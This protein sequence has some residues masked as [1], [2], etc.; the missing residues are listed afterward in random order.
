MDL[1]N[2]I[3]Y[4]TEYII[5]YLDLY[6]STHYLQLCNILLDPDKFV[7]M[8]DGDDMLLKDPNYMIEILN[9]LFY[10][11]PSFTDAKFK[12]LI[13]IFKS[14]P[15]KDSNI[16]NKIINDTL[17]YRTLYKK[18]KPDENLD[19]PGVYVAWFRI[20]LTSTKYCLNTSSE[21]IMS[22]TAI[23]HEIYQTYY[24]RGIIITLHA[25]HFVDKNNNTINS[26]YTTVMKQY[27]PI[28]VYVT[29]RKDSTINNPRYVITQEHETNMLKIKY[30]N[31][32]KPLPITTDNT[33]ANF[34]LDT[35]KLTS[36]IKNFDYNEIETY[37]L[38]HVKGFYPKDTF[39]EHNFNKDPE[40]QKNIITLI[41]NNNNVLIITSGQSGAGKTSSLIGFNGIDGVLI[42]TLNNLIDS[43][44]N[45]ISISAINIYANWVP[46]LK[47]FDD[48]NL[49]RYAYKVDKIFID[50]KDTFNFTPKNLIWISPEGSS[51]SEIINRFLSLR[52]VEPT[53][54]NPVSSRS[55]LI[56]SC[57][58]YKN[59]EITSH[60][61]ICDLAGVEDK[62]D[63]SYGQLKKLFDQYNNP[64]KIWFNN[65][66][67][68]SIN[69]PLQKEI[70]KIKKPK[71]DEHLCLK[72]FNNI[73]K[74]IN[75]LYMTNNPDN[76]KHDKTIYINKNYI[77]LNN[78]DQTI[79]VG[80][81]E[82]YGLETIN[83]T[84]IKSEINTLNTDQIYNVTPIVES[85]LAEDMVNIII[86]RI[87]NDEI[88]ADNTLNTTNTNILAIL[89]S[90]LA[91][92]ELIYDYDLNFYN[93]KSSDNY[94]KIIHRMECVLNQ[95]R[96]LYVHIR[97]YTTFDVSKTTRLDHFKTNSY[98]RHANLFL[99]LLGNHG[100]IDAL[101]T[102]KNKAK[103]NL[104][105]GYYMRK[106]NSGN[107]DLP[108]K[109][110]S[111]E[112]LYSPLIVDIKKKIKFNLFM[113]NSPIFS[114]CIEKIA[115][116]FSKY[117]SKIHSELQNKRDWIHLFHSN[118]YESLK[119]YFASNGSSNINELLWENIISELFTERKWFDLTRKTPD[120]YINLADCKSFTIDK[121]L[122][123]DEYNKLPNTTKRKPYKRID[124]NKS[125]F[126]RM[127]DNNQPVNNLP[128][129]SVDRIEMDSTIATI[130]SN[131][132]QRN[133]IEQLTNLIKNFFT[134]EEISNLNNKS[135]NYIYKKLQI[136]IKKR[137]DSIIRD[138]ITTYILE[139]N[140][141]LRIMEGYIINRSLT[142][143]RKA[144]PNFI[145]NRL[146][147]DVKKNYPEK[148][149]TDLTTTYNFIYN[150]SGFNYFA[151]YNVRCWENLYYF[152]DYTN[153]NPDI[154]INNN[155][156][157]NYSSNAV[158]SQHEAEIILRLIFGQDIQYN[159]NKVTTILP[160]LK[161]EAIKT[162][163]ILFCVVNTS[164]SVNNPPNPPFINTNKLKLIAN[165]MNYL[166]DLISKHIYG[167]TSD[168]THKEIVRLMF[169]YINTNIE[170]YKNSF[171]KRIEQ[172]EFYQ[173]KI[174]FM[175]LVNE[176]VSNPF[177]YEGA[178]STVT[179]N[180][181]IKEIDM[182]NQTTLIGTINIASFVQIN[183]NTD[184]KKTY[185]TALIC[186]SSGR[187]S[188]GMELIDVYKLYYSFYDLKSRIDTVIFNSPDNIYSGP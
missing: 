126:W 157:E 36:G 8:F 24:Q 23:W 120:S 21:T 106:F 79:N 135:Y 171:K 51:L 117:E 91:D 123:S 165:T 178:Y 38:G 149:I 114:L 140:M 49:V 76:W 5:K 25:K 110:N 166:Y 167:S 170:K 173:T 75:L 151:P 7:S 156:I 105:S 108:Y 104:G 141:Q 139:Y 50:G 133:D 74:V 119:Y 61:I 35:N 137:I 121:L 27:I 2:E 93:I 14:K 86:N 89:N 78:N 64:S 58:I 90:V 176:F 46:G 125:D 44:Y 147:G 158:N 34:T 3:Y 20:L 187:M 37:Y 62:F 40:G 66:F 175:H 128:N 109:V 45:K 88:E 72:R 159:V 118:S 103:T 29:E 71:L 111:I 134:I 132:D 183:T 77:T 30:N 57:S 6:Y 143:M 94:E 96:L 43:G 169:N 122:S 13:N 101:Q 32:P 162:H 130:I 174:D 184:P 161:L 12:I 17:M 107:K 136:I 67:I 186:S 115:T 152:T 179:L 81:S 15:T 150:I 69:N 85:P 113:A 145:I 11:Y 1:I 160:V 124:Y 168:Y 181:I 65:H 70:F 73:M 55:H 129:L 97:D 87:N 47:N 18:I 185:D 16:K 22:N 33:I 188:D 10:K 155:I 153:K 100:F 163:L 144:F 98:L 9:L 146:H 83:P 52:Q 28:S 63:T 68:K 59:D 39:S 180:N 102:N 4:N 95:Y 154:H 142:E 92:S 53:K 138:I 84:K 82:M 60:L 148:N 31:Y 99:L 182:M 116:D 54:N 48:E 41:N 56:I 164:T 112:R 80:D 19:V 172:F 42:I 127:T 131:D 26:N 177:H